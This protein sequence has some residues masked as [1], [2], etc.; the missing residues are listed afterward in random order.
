MDDV[1]I[2]VGL[3]ELAAFQQHLRNFLDGNVVVSSVQSIVKGAA[4]DNE[5]FTVLHG[6]LDGI[7][8]G[9]V[10]VTGRH[11][12]VAVFVAHRLLPK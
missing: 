11:K 5:I 10:Q 8:I 2:V 1:Q 3:A 4:G 6:V 12:Q 9:A 7:Q